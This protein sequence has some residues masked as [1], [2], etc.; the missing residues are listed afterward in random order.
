[1]KDVL[2]K[3]V[4]NGRRDHEA[5]DGHP[6]AVCEGHEGQGDDEA[7]HEGG[8]EDDERLGGQQVEEE[9]HDPGE[10][11]LGRGLEVGQPVRDDGEEDG[12]EEQVGDADEEVCDDELAGAVE[13][14]AQ[15]LDVLEAVL[16]EGGHVGDGHEGHEGRPE[17]DGVDKGLDG[18]L[19]RREAHPHGAHHDGEPGVHGDADA[20]GHDVAVRLDQGAVQ[21]GE[22]EVQRRRPPHLG[23]VERVR[24]RGEV[25]DE[26]GRL[27]GLRRLEPLRVEGVEAR[28]RAGGVV[29]EVEVDELEEELGRVGVVGDGGAEGAKVRHDGGDGP[30]EVR[31]AGRQEHQPVEEVEGGRGRLVDGA[32][33]DEGV[34]PG[35]GAQVAHDL[36]RGGRVEARR[37]LVEEQ[38]AR[39]GDELAG[40]ADA[41]LLPAR[42]ALADGRADERRRLRREPEGGQEGVDAEDAFFPGERAVAFMS[43]LVSF[44]VEEGGTTSCWRDGRKTRASPAPSVS[45]SAR[46]LVPRS[47][48]VGERPIATLGCR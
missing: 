37:G 29:R 28:R 26:G 5:A 13:P 1:M 25:G 8:H 20:V 48:S 41:A 24:G 23:Q 31:L 10:E 33:D 22:G 12:D 11:G 42:Y 44:G 3:G 32:D 30:A 14:V 35:H 38:D 17:E 21:E 43:A 2:V 19:V 4:E 6:E 45:R 16:E 36:A 46:L 7:G 18:L 40:H 39:A 15:V 9:P 34:A 47:R 27:A